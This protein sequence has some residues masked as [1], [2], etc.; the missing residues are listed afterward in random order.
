MLAW[1]FVIIFIFSIWRFSSISLHRQITITL[2]GFIMF[3]SFLFIVCSFIIILST[4]VFYNKD[5]AITK[6]NDIIQ[7][8]EVSSEIEDIDSR[9]YNLT[10]V[11]RR[12]IDWNSSIAFRKK[13][14]ENFWIGIYISDFYKD[15]DIKMID[16][17]V[18]LERE[19]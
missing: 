1:L 16:Y 6:Y 14:Y 19:E 11:S 3:L 4:V 10:R 7:D 8:M 9:N 13:Y 2:Y 17:R 12:I 15:E 5:K 18:I